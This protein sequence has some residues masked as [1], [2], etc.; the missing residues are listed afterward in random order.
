MTA[1]CLSYA[2]AAKAQGR[3]VVGILCEFTP[4]ELIMAA[5][6][7]P[8]CLCG[9][10]AEMASAAE[11]CLPSNLCPL[12]KSTFGYHLQ[13][14][15]PFLEMASLIVAETTCDGKK[16]MYELMAQSRPM[17]VLELPQKP[18][19][20][21]A[22]E[23]WLCELRKLKGELERRFGVS[24]TDQKLREAI[25][26][27][28]RERA[29]RRQLAELMKVDNPPLTGRQLLELKSTISAIPEDFA[30]Y[31]KALAQLREL[32]GRV[33]VGRNAVRVLLTG[34][35]MVHGAERVLDII[36]DNGGL[37]VCSENCTG[38]KPI[39]EDVKLEGS[40]DP[41]RAIAEKYFHL[42]CSVMTPNERRLDSLRKLV[43]EYRPQ[44][45]IELIWQAC[46]TYDVESFRVRELAGQLGLP[47]LRVET[48]YSPSD[49]ARI[50][51]RVQALFETVVNAQPKP[52]R[53]AP[54]GGIR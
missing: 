5:G 18:D 21:Q 38:L 22:F 20:P 31:E 25:R 12:I 30:Q 6:A 48:D 45:I 43:Q 19:D 14:S 16:K 52:K 39:L 9:G 7:V 34:V 32:L 11:T 47:Y 10:S 40:E 23:H 49:S 4:R 13:G 17:Y 44:C 35:P 27:M 2:Q 51:V 26:D 37:A 24:I 3:P 1:N 50:A 46:L 53:G 42:P 54:A 15:N 41:L 29:L 36:E 33:R 8:V 28:N